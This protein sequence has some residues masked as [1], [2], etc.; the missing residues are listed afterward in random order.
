[1]DTVSPCE[2]VRVRFDGTTFSSVGE[3]IL[4]ADD[5]AGIAMLI[6]MMRVLQETCTPIAPLS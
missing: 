3:T 1:M 5:K 4:G 2:G 6:E